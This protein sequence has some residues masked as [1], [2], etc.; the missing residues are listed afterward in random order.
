MQGR[1][2]EFRERRQVGAVLPWRRPDQGRK[3]TD[4]EHDHKEPESVANRL[5]HVGS[6]LS[7]LDAGAGHA[8]YGSAPPVAPPAT[9]ASGSRPSK[10]GRCG[11]FQVPPTGTACNRVRTLSDRVRTPNVNRTDYGTL[12]LHPPHRQTVAVASHLM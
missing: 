4:Y 11:V 3:G 1:C 7:A 6:P 5:G 2:R 9:R 8:E 10:A 12:L